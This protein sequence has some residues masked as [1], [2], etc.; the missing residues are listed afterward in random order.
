[1]D[2]KRSKKCVLVS[3]GEKEDGSLYIVLDDAI[4]LDDSKAL[5]RDCFITMKETNDNQLDEVDFSEDELSGLGHYIL[6]RIKA[7]KSMNE[8]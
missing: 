8:L 1:M 7:F 3:I 5:K 4:Q 6:A 2:I